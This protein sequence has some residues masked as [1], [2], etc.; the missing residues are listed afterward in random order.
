M[1]D[2]LFLTRELSDPAPTVDGYDG[3]LDGEVFAVRSGDKTYGIAGA[4][5]KAE[6]QR[7]E[8]EAQRVVNEQGRVVAET[9]RESAETQRQSTFETNEA[10]REAAQDANDTAQA[11][12]NADQA[13]N[14]AAMQKL[15]P[16]ILTEGQYDPDTLEPTIEGEPNRMYFVPMGSSSL[17]VFALSGSAR[18][19]AA[20]EAG[21][22]YVEWMWI[23]GAWEQMGTSQLEAK[24]ITT[25]EIDEVTSDASPQGE[26]YLSLTG[27][28]YLW[29]RVKAWGSSAFA[30]LTH[31]HSAADVTSGTFGVE[32]GG[33]GANNASE[34]RAN[35]G[36]ASEEELQDV[37]D[38]L[39]RIVVG[40]VATR[41]SLQ[42]WGSTADDL[43]VQNR[44]E[45]PAGE[46]YIQANYSGF[47]L[48][49]TPTG[50]ERQTV[51]FLAP[52]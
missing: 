38:S 40:G 22:L 26:E 21:N 10:A 43:S 8:N 3:E 1:A 24:P 15:S 35:I 11:K 4:D 23:D 41:A 12:N 49:F 33:T 45:T 19:E 42:A 25:D 20:A 51:L 14:N 47:G 34:A 16:V 27:L 37:R 39:S 7:K 13:A 29:A 31:Q 52:K 48:F 30:A 36:A 50:G 46:I 18:A 9:A 32:R 6:A 44:Y 5:G 2:A 17:E 28:S